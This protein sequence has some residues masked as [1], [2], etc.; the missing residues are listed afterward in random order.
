[1]SDQNTDSGDNQQVVPP[2]AN[3]GDDNLPS[4]AREKLTKANNEAAKYR[5]ELRQVTEA[6]T[7]ALSQSESLAGE[8]AAAEARAEAAEK[9]LLK[10]RV[11]M[12]ANV[13]GALIPRLQGSTEEE[14]KADAAALLASFPSGQF[15]QNA[16]DP[17]QGRGD[18][19]S[20][21]LSPGAA[22]IQKALRGI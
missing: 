15:K 2:P 4:W 12:E 8:K 1:M 13:P 16:T 18:G 5:T 11:A 10:Y 22:F 9:E 20:A 21:G 17:S 3:T 19:Q 7:T 14:L 6:H